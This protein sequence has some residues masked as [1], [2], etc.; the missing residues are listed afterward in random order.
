MEKFHVPP[1]DSIL[2]FRFAEDPCSRIYLDERTEED[3][4]KKLT[5]VHIYNKWDLNEWKWDYQTRRSDVISPRRSR[6][7]G[8]FHPSSC[9]GGSE[10]I[11]RPCLIGNLK[12]NASITGRRSVL[13]ASTPRITVYICVRF[14]RTNFQQ[15]VSQPFRLEYTRFFLRVVLKG[16]LPVL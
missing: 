1:T 15:S 4:E 11:T 13:A 9:I 14:I 7:I 16:S 12:T 2:S 10:W 8:A 5:H 6:R 3:E